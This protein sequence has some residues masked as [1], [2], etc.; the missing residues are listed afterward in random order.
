MSVSS[1]NIPQR[2]PV[3][4]IG[5]ILP[6]DKLKKVTISFADSALYQ[7]ETEKQL[8]PPSE[9]P[10]RL[11]VSV[12]DVDMI[13]RKTVDVFDEHGITI[14]DVPAGRGFHW[15][16]TIDVTAP[17]NVY[18]TNQKDYLQVTN[19]VPLEQY[20]ACVAV[21][22]MSARCPSAFLEAQITAARSWLLANRGE[23]HPGLQIDVCNDDCCQRYQGMKRPS[24]YNQG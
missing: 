24:T 21:S 16:K 12:N 2:E 20:L 9:V 22:E 6:I 13:I 11:D 8:N 5:I 7:I 4:R 15:E 1:S 19:E 14:H 10:D 3:L 17:G 18:I 23:N